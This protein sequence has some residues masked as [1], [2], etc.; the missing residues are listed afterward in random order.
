MPYGCGGGE[1]KKVR[2]RV[3]GY[4]FS[5]FMRLRQCGVGRGIPEH[6]HRPA[7]CVSRLRL[8]RTDDGFC[9][10][11]HLR[12]PSQSGRI[13]RFLGRRPLSGKASGSRNHFADFGCG[14]C[15][16][17]FYRIA[18]GKTGCELA[19]GFASNG[20]GAHSPGGY[21][22]SA[23]LVIEIVMTLIFLSG[24]HDPERGNFP[25]RRFPLGSRTSGDLESGAA[26]EI[27]YEDLALQ[28]G[29]RSILRR[30]RRQRV[31]NEGDAL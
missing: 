16:G 3:C 8:D 20:F 2:G 29:R 30:W 15:G 21:S 23:A 17:R 5:R 19:A 6:R 11:P 22:W 4:V 27:A 14:C 18:S 1:D 13:V 28:V 9:Y 10:R 12:L 25:A 31:A 7:G 26:L 24:H